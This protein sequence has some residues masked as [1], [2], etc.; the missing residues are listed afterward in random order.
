MKK[1]IILMFTIILVFGS[2]FDNRNIIDAKEVEHLGKLKPAS[3]AW[4]SAKPTQIALYPQSM[5]DVDNIKLATIQVLYE[6]KNISFLITWRDKRK[7]VYKKDSNISDV[8]K[9][10]IQFAQTK[11][12]KKLPYIK[13]GSKNRIVISYLEEAHE[14]TK[15][16]LPK[17]FISEGVNSIKEIIDKNTTSKADMEYA[18]N[19]WKG[20]LTLPMRDK[21]LDLNR[22]SIAVS[23][24]IWD[25]SFKWISKWMGVRLSSKKNDLLIDR[26]SK[27]AKGNVQKGKK[28]YITNCKRCHKTDEN[29]S[30]FTNIIA[31]NL[32]NI[33]GY[34]TIDYLIE[35]IVE[36]SAIIVPKE[37]DNNSSSWYKVDNNGTIISVMPSFRY[38]GKTSIIDIVTYL[39]TFKNKTDK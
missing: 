1:L 33:G 9:F 7:D 39:Q 18:N 24:V 5:K 4:F 16:E 17:M 22:S 8:D 23:F 19:G 27:K 13:M 14:T 6:K 20:T 34:S 35:S 15:V 31:P 36:P 25:G 38:L 37:D 32:L 12:I 3:S 21:Y 10:S 29:Q 26:L 11:E 2:T 30:N 28:L